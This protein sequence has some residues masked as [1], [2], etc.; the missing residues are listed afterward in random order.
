M[1]NTIIISRSAESD[2]LSKSNPENLPDDEKIAYRI[3]D[4]QLLNRNDRGDYLDG[5]LNKVYGIE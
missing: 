4:C 2:S 3:S 5:L 1:F